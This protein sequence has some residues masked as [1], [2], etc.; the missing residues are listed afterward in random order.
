MV[1]T[2]KEAMMFKKLDSGDVQ[3]NLCVHHCLI[4]SG[5]TGR[6]RTRKNVDGTLYALNYGYVSSE[7]IDPIEKKPLY[8]FLPGTTTYS[9]GTFGCNFKCRHCQ[10][11]KISMPPENIYGAML[12]G[13]GLSRFGEIITPEEVIQRALLLGTNSI[14]FTY[15]EPTVWYE[16]IY[17]TAVLAKENDLRVVLVTNGYMT[18]EA[19]ETLAPYIDAYRVDLKSFSNDFYKSVCAAT[20]DPV[21]ESASTAK[22]LGLHVEIVTLIIPGENDADEEAEKAAGWILQNIGKETPV[23][24]NAFLPHHLMENVLPTPDSMLDQVHS[25][26]VEAG[27]EFVYI[28]NTL[29]EYQNTFCP[30]CGAFLINRVYT[31]GES[32]DLKNETDS[33]G[34]IIYYCSKCLRKIPI[35]SS[36]DIFF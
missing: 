31:F 20:L 23:H 21:L 32:V 5:N 33:N 12:T 18:K 2:L 6:C 30:D 4:S 26:Y 19:I 1:S 36:E 29:S 28:G 10:N 25:I 8:H 16:F 34:Q 9:L 27:L 22:E 14:S 35:E 15:N 17:D 24:I 7:A 13:S 11:H 3:C